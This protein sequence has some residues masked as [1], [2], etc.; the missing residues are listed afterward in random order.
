MPLLSQHSTK[1]R[2][3]CA[4]CA[5][6]HWRTA[7]EHKY[8]ASPMWSHQQNYGAPLPSIGNS[9]LPLLKWNHTDK[10]FVHT[11]ARQLWTQSPFKSDTNTQWSQSRVLLKLDICWL[12]EQARKPKHFAHQTYLQHDLMFS[13][14]MVFVLCEAISLNMLWTAVS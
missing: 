4:L 9:L 13:N 2:T 14:W 1:S 7:V 10:V 12:Q 11:R 5:M 8:L 6:F 3:K